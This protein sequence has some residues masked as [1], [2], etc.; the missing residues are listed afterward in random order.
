MVDLLIA[1]GADINAKNKDG[2][3][4]LHYAASHA[5]KEV[6]DLLIAKGA[7]VNESHMGIGLTELL[8]F[9]LSFL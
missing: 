3:T 8:R 9:C 5:H 7:D 6:A 1:K 2:C 4:P